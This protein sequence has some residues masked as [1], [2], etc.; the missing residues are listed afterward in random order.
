M[1]CRQGPPRFAVVRQ[2][3][4]TLV[5]LLVVIAIIAILTGL[6]IPAVQAVRE[7]AR[8]TQCQNNFRQVSLAVLNYA[9]ANNEVLPRGT[10]LLRKASKEFRL[11]GNNS[12]SV[13]VSWRVSILPYIESMSAANLIDPKKLLTDPDNVAAVS[14]IVHEFQC[15]SVPGTPRTTATPATG[16]RSGVVDQHAVQGVGIAYRNDFRLKGGFG[17]RFVHWMLAEKSQDDLA[18]AEL[19]SPPTLNRITDGLSQTAMLVESAGRPLRY[20]DQVWGA[21]AGERTSG[22]AFSNADY[23]AT[24]LDPPPQKPINRR[25]VWGIFGFHPGGAVVSRFDGS[26]GF[27][28]E[29]TDIEVII[30]LLARADREQRPMSLGLPW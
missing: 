18:I 23:L 28:S 26:V 21:D 27:L 3:G 22:W 12:S 5:E 30:R 4:F 29:E 24:F 7:A 19:G 11:S 2:C 14:T 1:A 20:N 15:P 25:N 6:L 13:G 9:S 17:S 10:W 8:K 16:L